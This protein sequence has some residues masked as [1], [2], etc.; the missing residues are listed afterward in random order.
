MSP[1]TQVLTLK[2]CGDVFGIEAFKIHSICPPSPISTIPLLP[3]YILGCSNIRGN[4]VTMIDMRE[5]MK[6][7]KRQDEGYINVLLKYDDDLY[8]LMFDEVLDVIE[9]DMS[10]LEQP[11]K[12]FYDGVLKGICLSPIPIMIID[13]NLLFGSKM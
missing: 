10:A 2:L 5:K 3:P 4:I 1:S 6:H 7:P 9:V 13:P 11:D 8:S 12:S